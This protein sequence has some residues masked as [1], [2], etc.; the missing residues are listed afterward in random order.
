MDAIYNLNMVREKIFNLRLDER[1]FN[2]LKTK[3]EMFGISKV[4]FLRS[5]ITIYNPT[6]SHDAL[7]RLVTKM[8]EGKSPSLPP[9]VET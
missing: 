9:Q 3:S 1:E 5:A 6:I 4:E 8:F 2:L 7:D